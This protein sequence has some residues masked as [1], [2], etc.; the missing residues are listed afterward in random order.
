MSLKLTLVCHAATAR[1]RVAA[2]PG[3]EPIEQR[4]AAR[5]AVLARSLGRIDRSLVAPELR[6]RQTADAL[7]L[8]P[9]LDPLLAECDHGRWTGRSVAD[10]QASEPA[11]LA[12]WMTNPMAAPHDGESLQAMSSRAA[13]WLDRQAS[14]RGA[15]VAVTHASMLRLVMMRV[16]DAPL[17]AFRAIDVMPMSCL[18]L[19]FNDRWRLQLDAGASHTE[20]SD[21]LE[22]D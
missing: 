9:V 16:L 2:F 22:N 3:D 12:I 14:G 4:A 1:M 5:L 10:L 18:T 13:V 6:A 8:A 11:G 15:V 17:A 20:I 7:G 21:C 19:S